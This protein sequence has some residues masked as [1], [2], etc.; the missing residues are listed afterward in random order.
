MAWDETTPNGPRVHTM[1]QIA[2]TGR[3]MSG[4]LDGAEG[5]Y[6]ALATTANGTVVAWVRRGAPNSVIAVRTMP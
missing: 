5:L 2:G 3:V 1:Q 6:P 4:P